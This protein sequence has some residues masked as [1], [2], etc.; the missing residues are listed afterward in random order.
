MSKTMSKINDFE[1]Q[2]SSKLI[3]SIRKPEVTSNTKVFEDSS[4][5]NLENSSSMIKTYRDMMSN[6]QSILDTDIVN[7][8]GPKFD[9][10]VQEDNQISVLR[11]QLQEERKSINK[12]VGDEY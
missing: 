1:S 5:I 3:T 6:N 10:M 11:R 4:I 2:L 9:R 12:L 7:D 8:L